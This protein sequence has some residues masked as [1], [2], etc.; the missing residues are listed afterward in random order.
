M[1][2]AIGPSGHPCPAGVIYRVSI[3]LVPDPSTCSYNKTDFVAFGAES[4]YETTEHFVDLYPDYFT[5]II[6]QSQ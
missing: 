2:L 3:I 4:A 6:V 1:R 5:I